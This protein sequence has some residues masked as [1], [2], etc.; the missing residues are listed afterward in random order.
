MEVIGLPARMKVG[1]SV[2]VTVRWV[3]RSGVLWR[4]AGEADGSVL[5]LVYRFIDRSSGSRR[6]WAYAWLR[7]DTAPDARGEQVV[8][9]TAPAE[10]RYRLSFGLLRIPKGFAPPPAQDAPAQRRWPGEIGQAVYT[11][12]VTP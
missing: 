8:S 7:A 5:R 1:Q 12:E 6:R 11:V 10:G 2:S 3:N 4:A 9:V